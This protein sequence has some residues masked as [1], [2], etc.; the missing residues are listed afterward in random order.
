MTR[1]GVEPPVASPLMN[2]QEL[3]AYLKVS[4]ATLSRWRSARTGPPF[5]R[6]GGV[7]RYRIEAV[8]DWLQ[9]QEAEHG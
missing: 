2:S 8:D 1:D 3:A 9:R 4:E 7:S 6:L 5:I